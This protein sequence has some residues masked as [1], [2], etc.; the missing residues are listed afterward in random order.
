MLKRT[1]ELE[2]PSPARVANRRRTIRV[3]LM[4]GG[5]LAALVVATTLWL[6][7]GRWVSADDA[8]VRAP[9]LMVTTDVSGIVRSV[10]VPRLVGDASKLREATG[11]RPEIDLDQTLRDVLDDARAAAAQHV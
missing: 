4:L 9:K 1:V 7:A 3:A 2:Q 5:I 8:Y 10:D 6:R 11:W